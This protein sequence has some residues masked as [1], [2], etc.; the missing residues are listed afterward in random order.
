MAALTP[1]VPDVP[2]RGAWTMKG[3]LL[4]VKP[5][6]KGAGYYRL[7]DRTKNEVE[8][9][10]AFVLG[11]DT[12]D[13]ARSVSLA[14]KA[15]QTVW[16]IPYNERDGWLGPKTAAAGVAFQDR[17]G[18]EA[19]GIFGPLT[20]KASFM[21]MLYVKAD[22]YAVPRNILRGI[23]G[24]ESG[25]D[26]GAVGAS[27]WDHG[28]AQ[29]NLDPKNGNGSAISIEFAMTPDLALEW[30]AKNLRTV[31]NQTYVLKRGI[32]TDRAWDVAILAHNSPKN[33]VYLRE[34]GTYPTEQAKTY[35]ESVRNYK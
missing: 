6:A 2:G 16:G 14:V 21:V 25:F 35:V 1:I 26:P 7:A 10:S 27:G 3:G 24:Y 32:S 28:L 31:Y 8:I 15:L 34:N 17:A 9:G 29:I 12:S 19:D 22:L 4:P 33:A 5:G 11:K 30:T 23:V 13:S 20:M 18:I